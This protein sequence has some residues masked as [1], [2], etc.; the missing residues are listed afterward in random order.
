MALK[1]ILGRIDSETEA[2]VAQ[3]LSAAREEADRS[4]EAARDAAHGLAEDRLAKATKAAEEEAAAMVAAAR[5]RARDRLIAEKR[6][7]LERA[8]REA[9]TRI[10]FGDAGEYAGI[11]CAR[12]IP[13]LRGNESV[14]VGTS[15]PG[16]LRDSIARTLAE[17]GCGDV[18]VGVT[19]QVDKGLLLRGER[20]Y[21]EVS[22]ST[23]VNEARSQLES[24]AAEVLFGSEHEEPS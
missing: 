7:Y 19:D 15:E 22:V 5:I 1:D 3:I 17:A 11:L 2:E 13:L 9:V 18:E 16:S 20:M 6:V 12:A 23:I 14:E 21:V 24:V 10:E 4:L 8:L